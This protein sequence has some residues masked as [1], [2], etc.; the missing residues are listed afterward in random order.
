MRYHWAI[1]QDG[2]LPLKVDGR[3]TLEQHLCTVT[4][5]WPHV[6]SLSRVNSLV[7]DP[8]F[9]ADTINEAEARLHNLGMSLDDIGYYYET[10][11]HF[12]HKVHIPRR[13]SADKGRHLTK[14][15]EPKWNVWSGDTEVFPGIETVVCCGHADDLHVLT[16]QST[17]GVVCVAS[18]AVLN[19]EWLVAWQYYWPNVYEAAEIVDTWRS[20][21]KILTTADM[22]IPGH[23]PPI[24]ITADLLS[25]LIEK[26]PSAEYAS[27]CPEVVNALKQ[28]REELK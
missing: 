1:L 5:I 2:Q 21:A 6:A 16:F 17:S 18:D 28:R 12:D 4:L 26:F 3:A 19:R 15:K 27:R 10:H 8:C 22:V 24:E 11:G 7:V 25:E 14:E 23:G 13:R 20:V 9:G